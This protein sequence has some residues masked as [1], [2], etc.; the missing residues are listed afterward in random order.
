[1][2]GSDAAPNTY[3]HPPLVECWLTTDFAPAVDLS[4]DSA[5]LRTLM[6]PEW[7]GNWKEGPRSSLQ[8]TNVMGDRTLRLRPHGFTFGW[9]G[10]SG[11]RYPRY[12][13]VR[14]GFV[15]VL[16]TVRKLATQRGVKPVPRRWSVNYVNR[17][18]RGTVWSAPGDWSFFCLWQS[19]PLKGLR[20]EPSGSRIE[21]HLPLEIQQASL[22]I[23]FKHTPA[24][25]ADETD[26]VW[27]TLTTSGSVEHDDGSLFDGLDAGRDIIVRSFNELVSADA[28]S[29]WGAGGR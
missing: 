22:T 20:V 11:E 8:L 24:A 18:P 13:S 2:A 19:A 27:L 1:M 4:A 15:S 5:A 9:L 25:Q 14:D 29:F 17:I 6:G 10:Y 3:A 16:D 21:W 28:K 23:E 7:P 12:E 26:N